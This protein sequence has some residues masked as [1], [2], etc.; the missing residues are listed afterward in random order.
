MNDRRRLLRYEV[1]CRQKRGESNRAIARSLG[2]DVKTVRKLLK[3]AEERRESG[4]T[5]L[6]REGLRS[7]TPKGSKL[8]AHVPQIEVW[9]KE[10]PRLT[11]QR[12]L[13][14]LTDLGVEVGYT[15][16]KERVREL[17]Q[18]TADAGK[19]ADLK[20]VTP[21]GQQ[22]Q[23]DWSPY[24]LENDLKVQLFGS[25]LSWSRGHFFAASDNTRR[26]TILR[27]LQDAFTAWGGVPVQGVTDTMPGVVD[28]WELEEPIL[29]LT[30]VDFAAYYEFSLLVSHR[31]YP[32]FKGKVERPFYFAELNLFNGRKFYSVEQF[33]ETLVWWTRERA[34]QRPHPDSGRPR[35]EMV[36][37]ERPFLHPLPLRPY[38]TRDVFTGVV[39]S[40]GNVTFETNRY[41]MPDQHI[42]R[43]VYFCVGPERIEFFDRS[44]R[45]LV[46][47]PHLTPGAGHEAGQGERKPRHDIGILRDLVS[48]WGQPAVDFLAG[49]SGHQRCH[50]SHLAH[51]IELRRRWS[52]DDIL[53]A[54]RHALE[55]GAYNAHSVERILLARFPQ[56]RLEEQ[57]A[58]ASKAQTRR[59]LADHPV[60]P[61]PLTD[62]RTLTVGDQPPSNKEEEHDQAKD[63]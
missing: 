63:K 52:L 55:Y 25:L 47:Y 34:L 61:R 60:V 3:E 49:L 58:E 41:R 8:D 18:A 45:R 26:T 27:F 22:F 4:E 30:F 43:L 28:R 38:D 9:L 53:A 44:V 54:L 5:V 31:Y 20:V 2:I 10:F 1:M 48:Q 19:R 21:P 16:V 17:K 24:S 46:E 13:E 57:L 6:E 37:E 7:R 29:N 59:I 39:D 62:Y 35:A 42:G 32:K 12:V 33:R 11:A 40:Y 14:M 51:L 36:Q 23:F 50:G 56:R 15:I